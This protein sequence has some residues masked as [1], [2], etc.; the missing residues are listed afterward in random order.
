MGMLLVLSNHRVCR[1][2]EVMMDPPPVPWGQRVSHSVIQSTC[3]GGWYDV[4]G[5]P[6]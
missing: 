1:G 5:G 6:G 3:G 2:L 4:R